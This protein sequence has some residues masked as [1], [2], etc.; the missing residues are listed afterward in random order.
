MLVHTGQHYDREMSAVF[1]ETLGLPEPKYN[2]GVGSGSHGIQ[3]GKMLEALEGVLEDE[4]P[5]L[6]LVYGDTNST[7]AGALMADRLNIPIAHVEASLRSFNRRM[8]EECGIEL[9]PTV[10]QHYFLLQL[11]RPPFKI[12]TMKEFMKASTTSGTSCT[13]R[14]CLTAKLQS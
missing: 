10:F 6:V 8:A 4:R 14:P 1:F 12:L 3:L 5:D 11:I 13:K 7:L 2:L 9:S